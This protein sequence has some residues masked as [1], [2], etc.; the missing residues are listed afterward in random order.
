MSSK[1][2]HQFCS[3]RLLQTIRYPAQFEAKT[4]IRHMVKRVSDTRLC[5][6]LTL[7]IKLRNVG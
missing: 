5:F 3:R 7:S 6:E 1:A 2:L 4:S